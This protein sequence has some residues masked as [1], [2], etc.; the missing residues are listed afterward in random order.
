MILAKSW[1]YW[2]TKSREFTTMTCDYNGGLT[3]EQFLFFEI[4]IV[5]GLVLSGLSRED[6]VQKIKD[7]NL[8]QCPTERMIHV[9]RDL[10][11]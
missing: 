10:K 6:I 2:K 8:F 4:R 3:R 5:A 9:L 7:E 1:K 11:P